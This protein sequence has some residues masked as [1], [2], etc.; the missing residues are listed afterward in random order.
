M[1]TKTCKSTGQQVIHSHNLSVDV[2]YKQ[3]VVAS[4]SQV[5]TI[6]NTLVSIIDVMHT[7]SDTYT[8]ARLGKQHAC[9]RIIGV[10]PHDN[11]SS[12]L[13]IAV[14]RMFQNN[15]KSRKRNNAHRHTASTE[16]I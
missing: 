7:L 1:E 16:D 12:A 8:I 4:S 11:E 6:L 14:R 10:C 5:Q 2:R 3:R 15:V 13:D 9:S